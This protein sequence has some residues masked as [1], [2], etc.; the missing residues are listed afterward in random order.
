MSANAQTKENS[1]LVSCFEWVSMLIGAI[2]VAVVVF[3]FA[4][5]VV[6]VSGDSMCNTLQDGDRLVLITQLY[7]L[8]RGDIV[9]VCREGEE[10]YIK[11]VIALAGDTIDID[12]EKGC[13]LLNGVVLDEP[14]VLGGFTPAFN[15]D[16]P[17]TVKEGEI[18]A[19]GDNRLWSLDCRDLGPF[20]TDEVVGEAAFHLFPLRSIGVI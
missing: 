13:V 7:K 6:G 15:F 8:D 5:R 3:T 19:M 18:F 17:Y 1:A 16:G 12:D 4:F 14:Y 11:R 20:S 2:L 9:V 10:P